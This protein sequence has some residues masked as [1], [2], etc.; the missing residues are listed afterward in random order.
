M[1]LLNLKLEGLTLSVLIPQA[2]GHLLDG[3]NGPVQRL[4]SNLTSWEFVT[5]F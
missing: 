2:R 3:M 5:L 4:F 1:Y